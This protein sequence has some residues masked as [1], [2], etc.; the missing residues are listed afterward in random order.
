M[1]VFQDLRITPDGKELCIDAIIAPYSYYKGEYISSITIDSEETYSPNGPSSEPVFFQEFSEQ[2]K[3]QSL[4]LNASQ[5]G[6]SDFSGHILYVYATVEGIPD[7]ST[8]CGWDNVHTLGVT[9]WWQPIYQMGINHMQK[10][11]NNCCGM[12]RE[13]IDYIL[14]LKA[15]ELALRTAQYPLANDRFK[16]WFTNIKVSTYKAPCGCV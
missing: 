15:F 2:N 12:P 5:L 6:W 11:V 1:V 9:L 10:V 13:F 8:P 3:Q 16:Q 4:I 7:S 14:R